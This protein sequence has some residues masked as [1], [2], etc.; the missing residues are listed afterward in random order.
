ML[1]WRQRTK[2]TKVELYSVVILW[3]MILDLMQ[4]SQNKDHQHHKWRQHKSW[5]SFPDCQGARDKQLMPY[6]LIPRSKW[7]MLNY[8]KFQK[9]ECPGIWI[10][11][12]RHKWPKSWSSVEDP[13]VPLES[14]LYGHPLAGLLCDRQFVKILLKY[15]WE[16]VSSWECLIVHRDKGL[17]LSVYVDDIKL[18]GKKQNTYQMWKV[19]NKEVDLGEPTSFLDHVYLG[20]TQRPC[21]NKQRYCK[22]LQNHVWLQSFRRSNWKILRS[23]NLRISSWSYDMEGH[24]KKCVERYCELANKTTQQLYKVATPCLDDHPFKEEEL[25]SVGDLS[26]TCSQIVL[27]CLYLARIGRPDILWSVNKLA[28]S[29]TKWTKACDKRFSR[30]ISYTHHTCDYKQYCHVGRHCTTMQAGSVSGLWFCRRSWRLENNNR[31]SSV[32]FRE[33]HV[34]SQKLDVQETNFSFTQF[35][36]SWNHF[37]RCRSTHGWNSSSWSLVFGY[38]SVALFF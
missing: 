35:H 16:K 17:F 2:N 15:G 13:V 10:R 1:N 7:K 8:W 32:H 20:R 33:S 28:R 9:S 11:L 19:L 30:L 26:N 29:I 38:W 37:S 23:E 3:K 14:N 34:C 5:I 24:A 31:R 12:P 4:Y 22:Q 18:A 36:R 6:L 21:E 25:K 27:K